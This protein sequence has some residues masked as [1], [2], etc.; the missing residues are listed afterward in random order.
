MSPSAVATQLAADFQTHWNAHDMDAFGE[1]FDEGATFVNRYGMLWVGREAIRAGHRYIH[2]GVYRDTTVDNEV[3]RAE[4]I[5]PGVV[6]VHMLSVVA[7]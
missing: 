6:T 4:E 2:E 7:P 1:L 3:V 5:A